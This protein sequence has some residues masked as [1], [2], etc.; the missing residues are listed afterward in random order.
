MTATNRRNRVFISLA[1]I[2][3]TATFLGACGSDN[4]SKA[5]ADPVSTV[6][7]TNAADHT[8]AHAATPAP[9][10]QAEI[11]LYGA[12]HDLWAEHMQ[13]TYATVD[14]FFNNQ[15]ALQPTLDRL[16]QNQVDIG[17]AIKPFYGDEAGNKL[18]ELLSAHINGA[19]PVL[20]A[21]KAGDEAGLKTAVDEWYA[22]AQE[23][24]DFLA[25]ANPEN[26]PQSATRPM[27]E[28]HITQTVAYATDLLKGDYAA[29]I[30]AYDEAADHMSMLADTLAQGI[31]AAFPAQ[32]G[33]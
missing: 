29:A 32:F 12:M 20:T 19:V 15:A 33:G 3:A 25:A 22:N 23:V 30:A 13:W 24:A 10:N 7:T 1:G 11:A 8:T 2:A 21:A 16:L 9:A 6:A 4:V 18:T 14:A 28:M 31:V 27:L 5:A 17:N 26:W